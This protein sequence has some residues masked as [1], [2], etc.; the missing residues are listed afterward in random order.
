MT[1]RAEILLEVEESYYQAGGAVAVLKVAQDTLDLG[2]LTLR[3]VNALAAG[4]LRLYSRRELRRGQRFPRKN[5]RWFAQ[6]LKMRRAPAAPRTLRGAAGYERDQPFTV[7]EEPLPAPLDA[8]PEPLISKALAA[9]PDL[10]SLKLS[11]DA[12]QSFAEAGTA[13][14]YP[15]VSVGGVAGEAP[16]RDEPL[17]KE[18]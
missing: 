16:V 7:A 5:W 12:A 6:H 9:R 13:T 3:Q 11:R 4:A 15:T 2:R 17:A 18:L 14:S 1:T 8:D 10:A